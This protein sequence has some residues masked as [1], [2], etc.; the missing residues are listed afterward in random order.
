MRFQ[1]TLER[2]HTATGCLPLSL[3]FYFFWWAL[4]FEFLNPIGT[5]AE[6][7]YGAIL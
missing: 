5:G 2:L 3:F 7:E 6:F 1:L 4:S